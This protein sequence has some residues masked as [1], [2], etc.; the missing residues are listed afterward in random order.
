MY[1]EKDISKIKDIILEYVPEPEKILLFGSYA[2]GTATEESDMDYLIITKTSFDRRQK[3][4]ALSNIR[5][6]SARSG[7]K[8]DF[9]LKA[10][11]DYSHD[12]QAPTISRIIAKEGKVVWPKQ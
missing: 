12:I 8:A 1:T 3:L 9:L 6:Q 7:Y 5:W 10:A 4:A 11:K 2:R